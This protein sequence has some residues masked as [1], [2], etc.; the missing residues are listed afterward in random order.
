[1]D[2]STCSGDGK[3]PRAHAEEKRVSMTTDGLDAEHNHLTCAPETYVGA[4]FT[5]SAYIICWTVFKLCQRLRCSPAAQQGVYWLMP[6]RGFALKAPEERQRVLKEEG[7]R[8]GGGNGTAEMLGSHIGFS[9]LS[10][11]LDSRS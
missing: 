5:V 8:L 7:L 9:F 11:R 10:L 6:E 4:K 1:M 3:D 2:G